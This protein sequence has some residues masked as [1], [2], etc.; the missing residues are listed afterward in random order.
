MA[1]MRW[2]FHPTDFSPASNAAFRKAIELTRA[3]HGR[4]ALVH[5]LSPLVIPVV[6]PEAY[7]SAATYSELERR[8]R[9]SA[10]RHLKGLAAR[11]KR[12]GV[13]TS[14]RLIEGV[15][16]ADR[17]VRAA[18][19]QRADVIVMGTHGRTGVTRL[20]LGSVAARVVATAP[21]PVLTVR[22][23]AR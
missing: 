9:N 6:G 2:I 17:I 11:A 1:G 16:V 7:I 23:R 15:P 20:V 12:A 10:A 5:I 21:C 3:L 14:T 19:A 22:S 8:T 18:R 4:L 13:R